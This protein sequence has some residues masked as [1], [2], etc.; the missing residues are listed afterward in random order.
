MS[1]KIIVK[2]MKIHNESIFFTVIVISRHL[3]AKPIFQ[4][5]NE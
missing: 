5:D 2:T 4:P 1:E 3:H